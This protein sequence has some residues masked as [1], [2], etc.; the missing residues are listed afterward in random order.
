VRPAFATE[1]IMSFLF[2]VLSHTPQWVWLVLVLIVAL[3]C[4]GLRRRVINPWR[5]AILPLIGI[6]TSASGIAQSAEPALAMAGWGIGLLAALP[7]GY[8]IGRLREVRHL[9][10]G[11]LELAGGWFML[12]FGIS[13]FFT[14]Y[15]LGVLFGVMPWLRG[16]PL[17]ILA[18][19]GVGGVVAGIG[20]GWLAGLLLRHR[21]S[22]MMR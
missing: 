8:A 6:G 15:A 18:S 21:F 16:Q 12:L 1:L 11:R 4:Y 7:L 22:L 10:D 2:Q 17:W 14:R 20:M 5:L 3:G 19:G 13:I 9:D